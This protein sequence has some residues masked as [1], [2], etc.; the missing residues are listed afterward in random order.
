LERIPPVCW[1]G[2][3]NE[4]KEARAPRTNTCTKTPAIGSAHLLV[5]ELGTHLK[6]NFRPHVVKGHMNNSWHRLRPLP[7][8]PLVLR[9]RHLIE[10][11]IPLPAAPLVVRRTMLWHL[12][13]FALR[14]LNHG[15]P[16]PMPARLCKRT[17]P[18]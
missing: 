10:V 4:H 7:A 9:R 15:A 5:G 14:V 11:P 2:F 13:R 12:N 6:G 8:A 18:R 17:L 3:L 1:C 16:R